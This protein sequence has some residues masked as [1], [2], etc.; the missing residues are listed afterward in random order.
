[1]RY[2]KH[3]RRAGCSPRV[4]SSVTGRKML[5]TLEVRRDRVCDARALGYFIWH[6][7]ARSVVT[8]PSATWY[9]IA[10]N[11]RNASRFIRYLATIH[12]RKK[13]WQFRLFSDPA[14]P[15]KRHY[16]VL[17]PWEKRKRTKPDRAINRR[18]KT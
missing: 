14:V 12:E 18:G 5:A 9:R 13:G 7:F 16:C 2:W 8:F 1:M 6:V 3:N 15:N 10:A 11:K 4:S 17:A